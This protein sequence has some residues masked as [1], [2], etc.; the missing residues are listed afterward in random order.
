VGDTQLPPPVLYVD[1]DVSSRRSFADILERYKI[2][3][4][5]AASFDE[6]RELAESKDYAIVVSDYVMADIDGIEL[7]QRMHNNHPHTCYMLVT[8]QDAVDLPSGAT[9]SRIV[10]EIIF[11]PWNVDDLLSALRR[12]F[13]INQELL[14]ALKPEQATASKG[15][16]KVLLVEDDE[17]HIHDIETLLHDQAITL[18]SART[19]PESQ[20]QITQVNFD[21]CLVSLTSSGFTGESLLSELAHLAPHLAMV[22]LGKSQ[23]ADEL[24]PSISIGERF[25]LSVKDLTGDAIFQTLQRAFEHKQASVHLQQ[26]MR[27]DPLTGLANRILF[28]NHVDGLL[29]NY[30]ENHQS[31]GLVIA[32]LDR[33]RDFNETLGHEV[34]DQLLKAVADRLKHSTKRSELVARLAGDQFAIVLEQ[35][36]HPNDAS[37]VAKRVLQSLSRP[38]K[39][40]GHEFFVTASLGIATYPPGKADTDSLVKD[41]ETAMYRA[42]AIGR[43]RYRVHVP[44]MNNQAAFRLSLESELGLALE[45]EQFELHYQ[46]VIQMQTGEVVGAEALLR[47]NHPE[48]GLISPAMF[49]SPLEE[50]GLIVPVG[51]WVLR[52]ACE[53]NKRWQDKGL[54]AFSVAVNIAAVQFQ[55]EC[56]QKVV[57]STLEASKLDPQY[58]SLEI[59]ESALLE[60]SSLTRTSLQDIRAMGVSISLDDFGTGYSSLSYLK[61]YPISTLKIDRSFVRDITTDPEDAAIARA[62]VALGKSLHLEVIAEGIET[63][64]QLDFL[65]Q[66]QCDKYQGYYCSKPMPADAFEAWL[67]SYTKKS[68]VG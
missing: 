19:L 53:Q 44:E 26:I 45:R 43:N 13:G 29:A 11:K 60:D 49:I 10:S 23:T 41:A 56:M 1:D 21:V 31:L 25:H 34:G 8:G 40:S 65:S 18:V 38:L 32:D 15:A 58:L 36:N 2:E 68:A 16:L 5:V 12:G 3:V 61:R 57:A 20:E 67:S 6:A 24:N 17:G 30:E 66:S 4:D 62:I 7:I 64:E 55:E 22:T 42:K 63:Q 33:F 35:L 51:E 50:T 48:R 39:F 28:R 27:Y 52:S 46:P 37:I 54:P 9:D 14:N 59:T 47:W